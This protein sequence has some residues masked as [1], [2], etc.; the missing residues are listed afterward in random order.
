MA[1][2]GISAQVDGEWLAVAVDDQGVGIP[3]TERALVTEPFH[4][5]WNVR[6]LR[7][8]GN[9]ARAVHLPAPSRGARRPS[10]AGGPAGRPRRDPVRSPSLCCAADVKQERLREDGP[11][12]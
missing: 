11:A 10:L 3:A 9:R 7:I 4:R 8:P 6:E 12:R 2:L 5:A 1:S